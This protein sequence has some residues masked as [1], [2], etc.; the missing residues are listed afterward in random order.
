MSR[1]DVLMQARKEKDN[2]ITREGLAPSPTDLDLIV[3]LATVLPARYLQ[4]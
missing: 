2:K 3:G 4:N 1:E